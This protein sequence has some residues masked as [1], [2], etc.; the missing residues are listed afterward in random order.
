MLRTDLR[1]ITPLILSTPIFP[2]ERSAMKN[3][4]L[5]D[6]SAYGWNEAMELLDLFA[7]D[8]WEVTVKVRE[9]RV[10]AVVKEIIAEWLD[11]ECQNTKTR[12]GSD[13]FI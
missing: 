5:I 11:P 12:R 8:G 1:F 6:L 9:G 10:Y 13:A 4:G 3:L 7:S 2:L